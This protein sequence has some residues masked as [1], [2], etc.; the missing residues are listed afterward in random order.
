MTFLRKILMVDRASPGMSRVRIAL[1]ETGDY[2]IKEEQ[3]GRFNAN[4][5][6]WFRPDL[7]L[8]DAISFDQDTTSAAQALQQEPLFE[9]T[10]VVFVDTDRVGDGQVV[11]GG[12][13]NGYSFFAHPVRLEEFVRCLAE[14]L[15]R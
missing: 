4:T 1:E 8:L 11:S 10:P 6:R 3:H 13:L 5:A 7:I 14:L 15:R 2:I 12:I 9:N